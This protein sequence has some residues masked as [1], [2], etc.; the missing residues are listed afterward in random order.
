MAD[1]DSRLRDYLF[2]T[3]KAQVSRDQERRSEAIYEYLAVTMPDIPTAT[4]ES[5]AAMI[6]DIPDE[7]YDGWITMFVD[8][9]METV[10]PAQIAELCDG[11]RKN[12]AAI[13][14]TYIMFMESERM[15][16]QVRADIDRYCLSTPDDSD[17]G[18]LVRTYLRS[19]LEQLRSA[20]QPD[21]T[22][23]N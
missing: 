4:A 16:K 8:R 5:I 12:D 10:D 2:T 9:L 17:A 20:T 14:L 18:E 23:S 1:N 22:P 3:V 13:V 11:T 6:P 7:I 21:G 19:R 15:E